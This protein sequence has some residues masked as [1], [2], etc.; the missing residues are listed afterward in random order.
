MSFDPSPVLE[1]GNKSD[2]PQWRTDGY[3]LLDR[4]F[5]ANDK[6]GK[7]VL[8]FVFDFLLGKV[9]ANILEHPEEKKYRRLKKLS[10]AFAVVKQ[11]RDGEALLHFL[12]FRDKVENFEQFAVLATHDG[13]A[14]QDDFRARADL[15][16]GYATRHRDAVAAA[17]TKARAKAD[18]D[19]KH[20][21]AVRERIREARAER[22]L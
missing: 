21:Q 7:D 5:T 9:V 4:F 11:V 14:W 1:Q 22:K 12:G 2:I 10:K 16:R 8:P 3:K 18:A 15:I 17:A 6:E 20:K 19:E 13:D